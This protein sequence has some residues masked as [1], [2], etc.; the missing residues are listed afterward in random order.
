MH[1]DGFPGRP[2]P[3]R[4][5]GVGGQAVE[6]LP[7]AALGD[8]AQMAVVLEV[9]ARHD[10]AQAEQVGHDRL[11][12]GRDVLGTREGGAEARVSALPEGRR[13]R[14]HEIV[15]GRPCRP[16]ATQQVALTERNLRGSECG[17]L[18]GG[19]DALRDHAGPDFTCERHEGTDQRVAMPVPVDVVHQGAVELQEVGGQLDD[20]T[21]AGVA[22]AGVVDGETHPAVQPRFELPLE[23]C[24]VLHRRLF[25]DLEHQPLGEAW[26]QR[27]QGRVGER[28]RAGVDEQQ[29]LAW[30]R[31]EACRALEEPHL[32]L[33]PPPRGLGAGQPPVGSVYRGRRDA[34]QGFVSDDHPV[35]E[36]H[37]RLHE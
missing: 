36:A 19:L 6:H 5:P 1:L 8:T 17:E 3:T 9:E 2:H 7:Q 20:V 4:D 21:K 10:L 22:G 16:W 15:D 24:V 11:A 27:Q 30:G 23:S 37:D 12:G 13:V 32:E 14:A 18:C 29:R 33:R 34:G 26:A 35:V 31:P 25:G 28:E